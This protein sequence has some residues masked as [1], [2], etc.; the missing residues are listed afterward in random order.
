MIASLYNTIHVTPIFDEDG[1]EMESA[2]LKSTKYTPPSRK[3]TLSQKDKLILDALSTTISNPTSNHPQSTYEKHPDLVGKSFAHIK[4][5]RTESYKALD[6][7]NG[8]PNKQASNQQSFLR[9][10]TKLL[11]FKHVEIIGDYCWIT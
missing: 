7:D 10:K 8:S 6:N 4:D 1:I 11:S 2:I 5:W 3:P 9:S